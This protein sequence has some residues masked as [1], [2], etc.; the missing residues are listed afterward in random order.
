MLVLIF[1]LLI[2]FIFFNG[3]APTGGYDINGIK[4]MCL[5]HIIL[6]CCESVTL[7][8]HTPTE[9]HTF[10]KGLTKVIKL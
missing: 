2:L 8:I 5:V 4:M 7:F 1:Y 10:D 9:A 6:S 3:C